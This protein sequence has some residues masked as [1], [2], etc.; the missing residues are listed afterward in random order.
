M[1]GEIENTLKS[2]RQHDA[3]EGLQCLINQL[4]HNV[5]V[6]EPTDL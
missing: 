5:S 2:H 1:I 3:T 6:S 4:L